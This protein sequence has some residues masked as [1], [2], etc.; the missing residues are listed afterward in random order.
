MHWTVQEEE[1]NTGV[2]KTS[3]LQDYSKVKEIP[4]LF[5]ESLSSQ[6]K[7]NVITD[8]SKEFLRILVKD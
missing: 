8:V 6:R 3:F 2:S 5:H 4:R 1:K 7:F